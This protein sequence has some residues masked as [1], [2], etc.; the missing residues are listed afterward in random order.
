MRILANEN[1]TRTVIADLRA[2]ANAAR[3]IKDR[4]GA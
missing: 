2:K 4:N 1:V 3:K